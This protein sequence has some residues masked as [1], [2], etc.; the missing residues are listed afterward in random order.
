MSSIAPEHSNQE[1]AFAITHNPHLLKDKK[2]HFNE[3]TGRV[4]MKGN[5]N[6]YF[7]KQLAQE[8]LRN[9]E[10]VREIE[11]ELVVDWA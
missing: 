7:E 1:L 6:T 2:L 8:A 9:I 10:G 11:N 5:V 3:K 4:V